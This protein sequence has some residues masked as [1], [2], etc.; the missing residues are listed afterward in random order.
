LITY[1]LE[2]IEKYANNEIANKTNS[3]VP[4]VSLSFELTRSQF[5]KLKE[6]KVKID[7]TVE[8]EIIPVKEKKVEKKDAEKKAGN[9]DASKDKKTEDSESET[10]E[11]PT[12]EES[13]DSTSSGEDATEQTN[14]EED[15]S[16]TTTEDAT[17]DEKKSEE[18]DEI[19]IEKLKSFMDS[20]KPLEKKYR[21]VVKPHTFDVKIDEKLNNI[22][23][24]TTE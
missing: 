3:T 8:E 20:D 19:L 22:R 17:K 21:T 12:S 18:T 11:E 10:K 1:T 14:S 13:K 9:E 7:E 16:K 5:L 6:V 4:K 23:I 15:T 2:E 24:L